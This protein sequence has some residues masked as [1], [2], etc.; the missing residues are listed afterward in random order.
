MTPS[1]ITDTLAYLDKLYPEHDWT[2]EIVTLFRE[3]VARMDL[4]TEQAK[5]VIG[6]YRATRRVRSPVISDLLAMFKAAAY[7][8]P[9]AKPRGPLAAEIPRGVVVTGYLRQR[10][11]AE[12]ITPE[13]L[14]ERTRAKLFGARSPLP[15]G[16]VS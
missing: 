6:E 15:A 3:R 12:G 14:I 16:S 9:M 5:A 7:V 1:A 4:N 11:A 13:E 8:A 10:A 2:A